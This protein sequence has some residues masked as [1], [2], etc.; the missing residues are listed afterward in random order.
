MSANLAR[1]DARYKLGRMFTEA[2][3]DAGWAHIFLRCTR[4]KRVMSKVRKVVFDFLQNF[5]Q[6]RLDRAV[7]RRTSL[8]EKK[9]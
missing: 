7:L 3:H 6:K 4:L 2:E 5:L 9:P 1:R 8:D